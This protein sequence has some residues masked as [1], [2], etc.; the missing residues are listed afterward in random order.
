MS[1]ALRVRWRYLGQNQGMM[2]SMEYSI[3]A[4][5]E[6]IEDGAQTKNCDAALEKR[7]GLGSYSNTR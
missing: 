2:L 7:V 1:Q 4:A 5:T 3:A 6:V